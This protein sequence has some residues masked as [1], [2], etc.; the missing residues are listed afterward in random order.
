M[1]SK[2]TSS[3]TACDYGIL[4]NHSIIYQGQTSVWGL[5]GRGSPLDPTKM[6]PLQ[7]GITETARTE[8][9][10]KKVLGSDDDPTT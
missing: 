2:L 7:S 1:F 5:V 9:S 10:L 4:S 8:E 6:T 3:S